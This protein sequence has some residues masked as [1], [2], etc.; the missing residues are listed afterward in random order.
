M[1]K[2]QR[3]L[4]SQSLLLLILLTTICAHASDA[5]HLDRKGERWAAATLRKMTLEEKVGQMIL[6]W[7]KT[8]FLNVESPQFLQL[9]DDMRRFHVMDL[10]RELLSQQLPTLEHPR[11]N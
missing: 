10:Y 2:H 4:R 9:S 1:T 7:A 8:Q 5:A 6:A 11:P 3:V